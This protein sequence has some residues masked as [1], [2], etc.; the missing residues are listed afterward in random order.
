MHTSVA[1][2]FVSSAAQFTSSEEMGSSCDNQAENVEPK[3][4][5]ECNDCRYNISDS[6]GVTDLFYIF[7]AHLIFFLKLP[8]RELGDG[9]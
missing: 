6:H 8:V 5:G 9:C 7:L 3:G 2:R 4:K 1:E